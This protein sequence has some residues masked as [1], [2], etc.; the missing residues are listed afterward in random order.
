MNS[1]RLANLRIDKALGDD[2]CAWNAFVL[3]LVRVLDEL[4]A[5]RLDEFTRLAALALRV[6][7]NWYAVRTKMQFWRFSD[8][9]QLQRLLAPV[10]RE[11]A[12]NLAMA[13]KTHIE[14]TRQPL[15]SSFREHVYEKLGRHIAGVKD[16]VFVRHDFI[17]R[18]F[19]AV[20]D[21]LK[22][23]Y[24]SQE[25]EAFSNK[26]LDEVIDKFQEQLWQWWTIS[27]KRGARNGYQEFLQAMKRDRVWAGDLELMQ[28]ARYFNVN[29]DVM[30]GNF[31]HH[32]HLN[33]GTLPL[34]YITEDEELRLRDCRVV[35][36]RE[37]DEQELQLLPVSSRDEVRKHLVQ[38]PDYAKVSSFIHAKG[39]ELKGC[40][41][42]ID[43]SR[44]CV[45]ELK[46]RDVVGIK[47]G[48]TKFIVEDSV[49]AERIAE[50][51]RAQ[52]LV[53]V[54]NKHYKD[55]LP[56]ITLVNER[57]AHWDNVEFVN[58]CFNRTE[59][60]AFRQSKS[61]CSLFAGWKS[62]KD[63]V[64]RQQALL[65][66]DGNVAKEQ[67]NKW[68]ALIAKAQ[69]EESVAVTQADSLVYHI[70]D[71]E[72]VTVTTAMQI[73]LDE[74]LANKYQREEYELS[75]KPVAR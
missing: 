14:R 63:A 2:N 48:A 8:K 36:R 41:V 35:N 11:L 32:I 59:D 3:G 65:S 70:S 27:A 24:S 21:D 22:S 31:T 46:Q 43:W 30:R 12:I 66:L 50:L 73:E 28:L 62:M 61:D 6:E 26:Q 25:L 18:Q 58:D 67:E 23:S 16:D 71:T 17:V 37:H 33:Y 51:R 40:T 15:C 29:L 57:G 20:V 19:D 7:N 9:K 1:S 34:K 69:R 42:P 13:D 5:K 47:D 52:Q 74:A 75:L 55:G 38:V 72:T 44:D 49:A 53:A 60:D 4:D 68:Q 64:R 10:M 56:T 54:W 39:D 45:A